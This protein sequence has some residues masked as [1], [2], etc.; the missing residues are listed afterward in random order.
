MKRLVLSPFKIVVQAAILIVCID[1]QVDCTAG[2]TFT[3]GPAIIKTY[4]YKNIVETFDPKVVVSPSECNFDVTFS[5]RLS[6]PEG[7]D[8]C[9]PAI[10]SAR[11][12]SSLDPATGII[13]FRT[14]DTINVKNSINYPISKYSWYALYEGT[15][16]ELTV[17]LYLLFSNPCSTFRYIKIVEPDPFQ[18]IYTLEIVDDPTI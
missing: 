16:T 5:C 17:N 15:E 11:T 4:D 8:I 14:T 9:D 10:N 12:E 7:I 13:T 6:D 1:A 3:S 18:E 2:P